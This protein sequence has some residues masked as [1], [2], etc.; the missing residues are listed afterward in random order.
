MEKRRR[1]VM[2]CGAYPVWIRLLSSSKFQSMTWWQLSIV[3]GDA[4]SGLCGF[5]ARFLSVQDTKTNFYANHTTRIIFET[6][7]FLDENREQ[8]NRFYVRDNHL[9]NKKDIGGIN[10]R[11]GLLAQ[12]LSALNWSPARDYPGKS[13]YR[14][15]HQALY[16]QLGALGKCIRYRCPGCL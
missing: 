13:L 8:A 6:R 12:E 11:I 15:R 9:I 16:G 2:F 5:F 14:E 10:M 7:L 3:P 4:I 1:R